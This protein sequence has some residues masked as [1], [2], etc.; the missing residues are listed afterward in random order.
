MG[1]K[2][3]KRGNCRGKNLELHGMKKRE[4]GRTIIEA[5]KNKKKITQERRRIGSEGPETKGKS[6][7]GRGRGRGD[8]GDGLF[9][10]EEARQP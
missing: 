10:G 8:H 6:S 5:Y 4:G 1:K 3:K 2:S 9:E 7:V